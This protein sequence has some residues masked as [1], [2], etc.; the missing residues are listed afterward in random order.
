MN[1]ALYFKNPSV[2]NTVN[3]IGHSGT[4]HD[5]TLTKA[6][7]IL[8]IATRNKG[9]LREY[10]SLL[11]EYE[12]IGKDL[13]VP[14]IQSL[15][16]YEVAEE[17]AKLAWEKNGHN[18]ILVEDISLS[19]MGLGGRPGTYV[20]AFCAE[21]EMR[22]LIS[23]VWLK[24]KDR[25]AIARAVL[26]IY[27]GREFHYS[28][29][30]LPGSISE[31]PK[32]T[33]GF[34][35]DDI[36]IPDCD[37]KHRTLA[38]MDENEKND[39]SMRA[40]AIKKF[41]KN[42]ITYSYPVLMLPEPFNS[43]LKRL[44][45]DQINKPKAVKFAFALEALRNINSIKNQPNKSFDAPNYSPVELEK[46]KF[47]GRFNTDLKSSSLGLIFTDI[48]RTDVKLYEN[49]NPYIWQ[50][51]PQRRKLAIAQRAEFFLDNQNSK[52]H[53]ILDKIDSGSI[54]H[55]RN[56]RSAT[57][58]EALGM[59]YGS[60][61]TNTKALKEIG[62]KKVSGSKYVSRSESMEI[63]LFN[64]IGKYGRS[65]FGVG[66]MPPVSG[67]RDVLVT[68][69]IGHMPIFVH[70]NSLNA[71][72]PE[73]Q[74]K[75][76]IEAKEVLKSL[77]LGD[78]AYKRAERNIGAALGGGNIKADLEH[79]KLLY[80]KAGV[81]LFRIYTING[82]PRVIEMAKAL[83]QEF[84]DDVE[85][86]TGQIADK[87]Q[88]LKLIDKDIRVDGLVFGHGGGMQCTSA[89][90]GMA[91]TTLEEIYDTVTDTRFNNVTVVA[92]GGVGTSVG[93]LFVLGVDL[94]LTNQKFVKG[95]IEL[96]DLFF[97]HKDGGFCHP[98]HG[99]A[100]APT[101]LIESINDNLLEKR[102]YASGRAKKV[103]G[104]PGYMFYSEKANSMTF[105]INEY[106]HYAARTLTDLGVS[107]ITELREF[108]LHDSRELFRIISTE[109]SVIAAPHQST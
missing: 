23:E 83:R 50:M 15:D 82:D 47:F 91:L 25:R 107:T 103:E 67:W 22:R 81:K 39:I 55:R 64:K 45:A 96:S 105:H 95:A 12:I 10:I 21:P 31:T 100:S 24:D 101:M 93:A 44:R 98:Y 53:K 56:I 41:R 51:G 62:Y 14:E 16:P 36:F 68:S 66:S 102:M 72:Y 20:D 5:K 34:G 33:N 58:E 60:I 73:R 63:G 38:Q 19:A 109:A 26:G 88:A 104:K 75:L 43:E 28:E 69:A 92:E 89:T 49:D 78:L 37:K 59:K 74:I 3:D 70:R 46:N 11:P 7:P 76:I 52:V 18:P 97:E 8:E 35:W 27:D 86:F 108:L 42:P 87:A 80:K 30:S 77:N 99:S 4:V 9:K 13:K 90:N 71:A 61:F 1:R 54:E 6:K 94:I 40:A 2:V 106:K 65:I 85:I 84:G 17:K 48:D 32:G 79:A 29:G 57:I